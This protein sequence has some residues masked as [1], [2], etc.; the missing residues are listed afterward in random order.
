MVQGCQAVLWALAG[1][2]E[3]SL[4]SQIGLFSPYVAQHLRQSVLPQI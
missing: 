1:G 3:V 2:C 4:L